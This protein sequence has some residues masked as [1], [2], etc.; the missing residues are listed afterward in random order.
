MSIASP[1]LRG[2]TPPPGYDAHSYQSS[3]N[4][5]PY[6]QLPHLLS[7][8]WLAYPILS[9]LFIAFRLELSSASAQ[10]AVSNAKGDLLTSCKAA[11][12]AATAAASMPR[13]M[14][15]ATNAQIADA[16]N[17]TMNGARAALVLSL[18]VMEAII[19]FLIDIYRS[20]FLCF[21]ELLIRGTLSV[22]IAAVQDISNFV[23]SSLSLIRTSIQSDI[24]SANSAIQSVVNA[25]NKVNPFG[26]ISAPQISVPSL[27]ALQN[28]TI[29]NT[30][31]TAL[32]NLN[33][34]LPTFSD[35]KQKIDVLVDTPFELV[36]KD[37]NDTFIGLSFDASVL[38]IPEQNTL[39]FCNDLDTS[40]V[41][42]LGR[43][44]IKITK[45]GI[46][47]IVVL[48][49]LLLA[50]NCALE[51]YKWRCLKQ[52]LEY[53]REAWMTDP[54]V[55]HAG[56]ASAPTITLSDHNLMI[57]QA[58]SAH[59]LLTRIANQL[60]RIFRLSPSQYTNLHWFFHYVFH[61]PALACFLIG[62]FGI[63]SVE[64][65][66]LAVHPLEAK[67]SAQAA[68]SV[69]D[70][71]NTIATSINGSM[72]NQ[73][74]AYA[75]EINGRISTMQSSINDGL[76][77]WVNGTTTTLNTTLVEFYN[78]LQSGVAT[79]F[80][81]T[82]LEE[83]IQEF[84][85]CFIGSKVD[86]LENALTF[87]HNNLNV[88]L[89]TVNETVL[90]LSPNDV[91]EAT[92]PIATAAVG[93]GTDDK[94]GL[95]GSLVNTY[96]NSLKK[97]RIMF[98]VFLG[99]WGIVVLM[100]LLIVFW[101]SYGRGWLQAYRRRKWRREQREGLDG[102]VYPFHPSQEEFA[103][104]K[105]DEKD[106]HVDLPSFTPM[107][108]PRPGLNPFRSSS[109]NNAPRSEK[110]LTA[111]ADHPLNQLHPQFEKSWDSFL[112]HSVQSH[113]SLV[114]PEGRSSSPKKFLGIGRRTPNV[115]ESSAMTP[116]DSDITHETGNRGWLNNMTSVFWRKKQVH[117]ERPSAETDSV[118]ARSKPNLTVSTDRPVI[119]AIETTSPSNE[120][121]SAWSVS[122]G[123]PRA[124]W[125]N[126]IMP[127]KNRKSITSVPAFRPK[128]RR[129]ASVPTDVNSK[130]DHMVV[131]IEEPARSSQS[132]PLTIPIHHAFQQRQ[133]AGYASS[134]LRTQYVFPRPRQSHNLGPP[135]DRHKRN[136]SVP[137]QLLSAPVRTTYV[138]ASTPGQ[139]SE[140]ST[141]VTRLL[142]TTHAR[143]SSHAVDP[144]VTP[145]DDEARPLTSPGS[146]GRNP[147]TAVAL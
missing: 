75:N 79:V 10:D 53:T 26:N 34:S 77:G 62:F 120:P 22:L 126:V 125:L 82:I 32:E 147:F 55:Y 80:N 132:T 109:G 29:P 119:P 19:N 101:H 131:N 117:E 24:S 145:F 3:F 70:F 35:L 142:T 21:L 97:E 13:Y 102:T 76:F 64:L 94:E 124:P 46:V 14:A 49:L 7:L 112:D 38:P 93:G 72:Y 12:Q 44:L 68:S 104:E 115:Q 83:P 92:Q 69:S 91:N 89:P 133:D 78:E 144:F 106:S 105:G 42:D 71:S 39:T 51:W 28:V 85:N 118:R 81:G 74:S 121:S 18:T 138:E 65:Q 23:Q 48:A 116:A 33:S 54:T 139:V 66:L 63:L 67:Y 31:Q 135:I 25:A 110:H 4:L 98:G 146:A 58:S 16:V 111:A 96:V 27:D 61:P 134:D 43:D 130:Y 122:P 113:E 108:S 59:P 41:D 37:I 45:I 40:V 47:L 15:Q 123:P 90:V 86:A 30:F 73:S 100:A 127:T 87:L 114:E 60:S 141:P 20:T 17:G 56:P 143:H 50:G 5:K 95:V 11:E 107:P 140:S 136:S 137:V 8:T 52:H 2:M 84:L 129:N 57:L 6:L 9:L 103:N 88:N 99:L 128:P 36:K 1:R